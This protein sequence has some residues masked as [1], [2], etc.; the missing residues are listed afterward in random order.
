MW[1]L[2][3]WRVCM[4]ILLI[5]GWNYKNY[6]GCNHK[7]W[8]NRIKFIKE[9]EKNN[10]LYYPDLPGFGLEKEPNINKWGLD[11]YANFINDY[12]INNN[13]KIDYIIGYSFGGAVALRYKNTFNNNIKLILISPALIRNQSKSRRFIKTP[14]LLNPLRN[15]IRNIYLIKLIKVNEMVYGTKFLRNTYQD[16]VRINMIDDLNNIDSKAIKIIYGSIDNMVNPYKV[17]D[18]VSNKY[19]SRISFIDGGGHDIA[20]THTKELINIINK[21]LI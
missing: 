11:D 20:N 5:H 13:L 4:N 2:L 1:V 3:F 10:N 14:S 12:I 9:L 16:I 15:F 6:Y 7:S 17:F 18:S 19:K 8:D 21:T